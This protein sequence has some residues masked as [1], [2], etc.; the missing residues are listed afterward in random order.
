MWEKMLWKKIDEPKQNIRR[1]MKKF[2]ALPELIISSYLIKE[3]GH[4]FEM[5]IGTHLIRHIYKGLSLFN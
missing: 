2:F 4:V 3:T 5:A 1:M